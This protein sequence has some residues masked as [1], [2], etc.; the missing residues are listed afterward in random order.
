MRSKSSPKSFP[1]HLQA[2][3]LA[4]VLAAVLMGCP[5]PKQT[6]TDAGA[7][8]GI[9]DGGADAGLP[10]DAGM[11]AGTDAGPPPELKI[12]KVLPPRGPSTGG[13]YVTFQGSGFVHGVAERATEAKK[14]TTIRFGSNLV[15]DFQI[16]DDQT[17]DVRAPPGKTGLTNVTIENANGLFVCSGC[18]TYFEEVFLKSATP[19]EGSLQGGNQVTLTG[20]G[21]TPELQVL[22]GGLSSPQVEIASST[23]MT[24]VAPRA[25]DT[26]P[27]DITVYSKNGVGVLRRV[28]RYYDDLRVTSIAPLTG[29]VQGGTTVVLSGRGF[30]GATS[31][32]FGNVEAQSF[33]VDG[34]GQ[35]TA[36]TPAAAQAGTVALTITT[37][38]ETW[39]VRD[40]FFYVGSGADGAGGVAPHVGP[41]AGG[42]TVTV[43]GSGFDPATATVTFGGA[44][45]T[46]TSGTSTE[47]Q[48]VV[49]PRGAAARKVDVTVTDAANTRTLVAGYT[50]GLSV[51]DLSPRSGPAAGGTPVAIS[52]QGFPE[53][54]H[55]FIGALGASVQGAPTETNLSVLTPKG[56]GGAPTDLW[57]R[58]AAD[59]ENEFVLEDVFTF[60]ESLSVGR[61]QP[62]RGAIAGGTLVQ[63]LGSGFGEGTLVRFGNHVAKDIK[64]I[65]SHT[66]TC[67]TPK[68]A[69]VGSVDIKVERLGQSDLLAGGFSYFD[70]RSISGGLSGGPLT[71]TLNITVLESTP[72][73]YGLPVPLATVMLGADPYTPFQGQTDQRGQLTFSDASLVKAQTV[74]AFKEGF[75]TTTV[76]SVN[77]ENL[78][79]FIARTG[80]DGSPGPPPPGPPPSLISGRVTGFKAPRPL[81][82]N[83]SLEARVFVTQGSLFAG[84]PFRGPPNRQGQKWQVTQD[85]GE[86]LLATRAGV[87]ATYAVLGVVNSQAKSF[88]PYLMGV[89]R[90]IA[91]SP[92]SPAT[93]QDI[94]LDMHLDLTVPVT[95]DQPIN[96]GGAPAPNQVYG[97]LDL[98]A[99]GFIPNPHNW[100][101]GTGGASSI[102]SG[103]ATLTF[104][105]FPQLDG[106]NFIFMNLAVGPQGIPYSVYF[107]RQPG[108]L[109]KG[110]TIGPMLP[111][112]A[113]SSPDGISPFNGTIGWN[114]E[115]GP[116]PDI[117][118]VLILKPT[119]FGNVTLWSVVLP[120]TENQVTLPPA[121]LDKLRAEEPET[122][123]FIQILSSRSPKFSYNQ[124]TYDTL[125][126]V[127]WSS[128][129][130]SVSSGFTP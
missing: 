23:E 87:R 93:N 36:V 82:P 69:G 35:I 56:Q 122:T 1:K 68:A 84:A 60:D 49:P 70:P 76:T 52:G 90:G 7:D 118:N 105:N 24:V 108:D 2:G 97:W 59:P 123:L 55:V 30:D 46:V 75:E 58:E 124:W 73:A 57:V 101:S 20:G 50:Y 62:D 18:F 114:V 26:G 121:A 83:E 109:S 107:R 120:G 88:E 15:Q 119:L 63:V 111:T 12:L 129:T 125:S 38:R 34:S 17:M 79:V 31:V 67:R 112:P 3:A 71:G 54:V 86:Y 128:F 47:L 32:K 8:A 40:G 94:I 115:P 10:V 21:F 42:N 72:G 19:K 37:P 130:V 96:I 110:L 64:V 98:G 44:P 48:V 5:P 13:T 22:F 45:A 6:A 99:E 113:I 117:H 11:D 104:P 85:G 74:T 14:K 27:V 77:A 78:T 102:T 41:A 65:D 29:P 91:T 66:L 9:E 103:S 92:D 16:I 126:G 89:R 25:N 95:I 61:V 51:S 28:Y 127:S 100:G 53:D 43:F 81:G 33:T 39:R 116:A 80:G 106:A 4:A